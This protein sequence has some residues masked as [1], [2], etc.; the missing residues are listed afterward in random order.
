VSRRKWPDASGEG[1]LRAF[2][3]ADVVSDYQQVQSVLTPAEAAA[4]GALINCGGRVLDL[5]VGTGRTAPALSTGATRYV[6]LDL[7][8]N[9]IEAARHAFPG[10]EFLVADATD[11]SRF[12]DGAFDL[13]VFSYNGI[14]YLPTD[15]DRLRCLGEVRRVLRN[16][17]SFVFS[18]HNGRAVLRRP[19][20][21]TPRD[22]T[23]AG[24]QSVRRTVRRLGSW[25]FWSGRG[26]AIDPVRG[27]L[28][29]WM[30][31]PPAVVDEV[32]PVGFSHRATL[33]GDLPHR[34]RALVT[35][36]WYYSFEARVR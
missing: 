36:W 16:G 19:S 3:A 17:G 31:T 35:P 24:Y 10:L 2:D 23:I 13:V 26:Y 20:S 29:T 28:L 11:L 15:A 22:R 33:P 6:G 5:G 34:G 27:G 14:D 9:M 21:G 18:S 1:N 25:S 4:L 7:A 12:D 32:E 30:S 8:P